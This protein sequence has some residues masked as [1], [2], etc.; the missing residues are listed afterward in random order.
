M[1]DLT[2]A[3]I[4]DL[5]HNDMSHLTWNEIATISRS[6][7]ISENIK[8]LNEIRK[9]S[10]SQLHAILPHVQQEA[11]S[12][13][14]NKNLFS[15]AN[16]LSM[17]TILISII[18]FLY[19]NFKSDKD[20]EILIQANQ[21]NISLME[22]QLKQNSNIIDNQEKQIDILNSIVTYLDNQNLDCRFHDSNEKSE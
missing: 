10:E 19:S 9:M 13:M 3:D 4:A 8:A 1:D 7:N 14:N 12:M 15:A 20:I 16:I 22:E 5:T 6:G 18:T 21:Q 17:I 11:R 2:W